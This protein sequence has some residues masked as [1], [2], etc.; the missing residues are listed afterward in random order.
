VTDPDLRDLP[1]LR[2]WGDE[3]R[4]A[5]SRAEEQPQRQRTRRRRVP[6]RRL[7][8]AL[9]AM[10]LLVPGA[11]ATRSIW[12]N[13]VERVA[14]LAPQPSTPAVR[15]AEGRTGDVTWRLGGYDGDGG[16]R[17]LQL[18]EETTTTRRPQGG[19]GRAQTP[20]QLTVAIATL[21]DVRF[22]IGTVATEVASVEVVVPGGRRVRVDT[23]QVPA[24]VRRRAGMRGGFRVYVAPLSGRPD[25]QRPP[26]VSAYGADGRVVG[27]VGAR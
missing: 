19:C 15:L 10:F 21:S 6:V 4:A 13:P 9:A 18:D 7:G 27:S 24:E 12:D 17:C 11:V 25:E 8:V 5:T 14:P 26:S 23:A 2:Q 1:G 16:Q 3:L 22:V 20:A